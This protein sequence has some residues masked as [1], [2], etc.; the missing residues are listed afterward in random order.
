MYCV[1]KLG[2]HQ[3]KV[4][5]GLALRIPLCAAEAGSVI[6]LA[7]VLFW[8]DGSEVLVGRPALENSLVKAKVLEHGRAEKITIYKTRR[9]KGYHRKQGHRQYFTKVL[10]EEI[11]ING[12]SYTK[13]GAVAAAPAKKPAKKTKKP[14]APA[15]EQPSPAPAEGQK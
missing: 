4:V 11:I 9:K 3:E 7:P 6:E 12:K 14:V 13:V 15:A 10:V 8:A 1:V 5:P 2:A